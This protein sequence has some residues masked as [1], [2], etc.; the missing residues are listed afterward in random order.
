MGEQMTDEEYAEQV[1]LGNI[2][3]LIDRPYIGQGLPFTKNDPVRHP[4][5]YC[6]H[7]SGVETMQI[8]K[9]ETFC[10]GNAMKYLFRYKH[11]G[12]PVE[13]LKKAIV[14]IEEEIKRIEDF[15][16][17]N[18]KGRV[19]KSTVQKPCPS[20]GTSAIYV[21]FGSTAFKCCPSCGYVWGQ[22]STIYRTT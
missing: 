17:D 2:K 1:R 6:S 22:P 15:G 12:K 10:I 13:D 20:C 4:N 19:E 5:H 18:S 11:K 8:A 16:I 3:P 9:H 14:N 7:P 21:D